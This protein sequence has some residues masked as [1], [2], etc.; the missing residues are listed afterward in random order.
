LLSERGSILI[1]I[2]LDPTRDDDWSDEAVA[3]PRN[4]DDEPITVSSIAQHATQRGDM[5]REIR[6]LDKYIGPNPSHQLL[7][8]DQ[9]T[10]AFEQ[11]HQYLQRPASDGH[12]FVVFQQKK[13][14]REQPKRPEG[15]VD[16]C[17][18]GWY[19]S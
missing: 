17:S 9:L 16:R 15:N 11:H 2:R 12:W 14:G 1:S 7:L 13:L 4:I 18:S 3:S 10:W 5:D 19:G 8:T 6:R